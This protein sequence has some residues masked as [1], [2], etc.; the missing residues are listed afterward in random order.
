VAIW[1][2]ERGRFYRRDFSRLVMAFDIRGPE[3]LFDQGRHLSQA[4]AEVSG[5]AIAGRGLGN[6][7]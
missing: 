5:G 3:A 1:I 7:R 4:G 6:R 2:S